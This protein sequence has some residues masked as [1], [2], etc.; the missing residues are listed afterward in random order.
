MDK[1]GQRFVAAAIAGSIAV[2][3]AGTAE[4]SFNSYEV[5]GRTV[6]EQLTVSDGSVAENLELMFSALDRSE[7]PS[8]FWL[9]KGALLH[10]QSILQRNG[11]VSDDSRDSA[12][13]AVFSDMY[14]E[15]FQAAK[16]TNQLPSLADIR[17]R[18][19][20]NFERFQAL[21]LAVSLVNY[22]SID[23][24]SLEDG[25][26]IV[27]DNKLYH[28]RGAQAYWRSGLF[29]S[30]GVTGVSS[31]MC[32]SPQMVLPSDMLVSNMNYRGSPVSLHSA[33]IQFEGSREVI[34][35]RPDVPFEL[36]GEVQNLS[37]AGFNITLNTSAGVF[38]AV[39]EVDVL[40]CGIGDLPY[41]PPLPHCDLPQTVATHA[42]AG[43]FG[44]LNARVYPASGDTDDCHQLKRAL[45]IMDGF[46]ILNNRNATTLWN[47]F[48]EGIDR[49]I[50]L[51]FDVI[52]LDYHV[53]NDYIQRN[54][55]ALRTFMVDT[56]P[57]L[58]D[59]APD[60]TDV[61][62]IAGSM[63]AQVV[64]YG[65]RHAEMNS[66]EHNTRLFMAFDTEYQGANIPIGLQLELAY[67]DSLPG[68]SEALGGFIDA[69][70]SPAARQLLMHHYNSG[71]GTYAPSGLFNSFMAEIHGLGLPL[72]SRNVGVANG[73]GT[74]DN[75]NNGLAA[76]LSYVAASEGV[77][78]IYLSANTDHNGRVFHGK[79]KWLGI[80]LSEWTYDIYSGALADDVRPGSFR[81]TPIDI[82]GGY[83]GSS[84]SIGTM[85]YAI[86]E[87][88]FVPTESAL[89]A[90]FDD[91]YHEKCNSQHAT[92]TVG[93]LEVFEAEL[94]AMRDGVTP[95]PIEPWTTPCEE[96][97]PVL[98]AQ[99]VAW[100]DGTFI[101]PTIVGASCKV[102]DIPTGKVGFVEGQD[103]YLEN[104]VECPGASTYDF[105][106][107]NCRL[108]IVPPGGNYSSASG[109]ITIYPVTGPVA[110]F[111]PLN[112]TNIAGGDDF[113][114]YRVCEV[115]IPVG[116]TP[117]DI[118][119]EG[120]RLVI[121]IGD[122][123]PIG[124][125]DYPG[126]WIGEAPAG[127]APTIAADAFYYIE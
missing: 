23:P 56:L 84:D 104:E 91:I 77:K 51:G 58:M 22:D 115:N 100:W 15:L 19:Q 25:R 45:V 1:L 17:L 18:T 93:N 125:P 98:C 97:E 3:H 121:D 52:T 6:Q 105:V 106:N 126:C 76:N 26:L 88:A 90:D 67:L 69:I 14:S 16:E 119:Q 114:S 53:G 59:A 111:C 36:P 116:Y 8:G 80:L 20:R 60:T 120:D 96:P 113:A 64:N 48:G 30:A 61:A 13:G 42:Y 55:Q 62:V 107:G 112:T 50:D 9:E 110:A 73:S 83:N 46:D 103:Y 2:A 33:S 38:H 21:P 123:C 127:T 95:T 66:E 28:P 78:K 39:S 81:H 7:L 44:R 49:F 109:N 29:V 118:E 4:N 63:G 41:Q 74:G 75:F 124:T 10:R 87:H 24:A 47:E 70:N 72:L 57:T 85:T 82:A 27:R 101:S 37:G 117:G 5:N 34:S 54:G 12:K 65:L 40:P 79:L 99:N 89:G 122:P 71:S 86:D 43:E 108:T 31:A 68:D 94:I 35:V 11:K 92:L 102:A 32:T